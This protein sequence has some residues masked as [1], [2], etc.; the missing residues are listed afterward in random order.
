MKLILGW[1]EFVS[2]PELHV[3]MLKAKIDTGARTSALH[4]EDIQYFRKR[5]KTKVRFRMFPVSRARHPEILAEAD[6]VG[7]RLV[8]SSI[9]VATRRPVIRTLLSL[10]N[11]KEWPIEVTLINREI[12]GFR[13]LIGRQALRGHCLVDP[14][15]SFVLHEKP[16]TK[17]RRKSEGT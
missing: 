6:L 15:A 5:G 9:G 2:L 10:G 11:G 14:E 12:M 8:R 1:R 4:A 3:T 17:K 16:K 13:M 7:Q